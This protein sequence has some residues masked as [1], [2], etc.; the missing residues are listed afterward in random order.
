MTRIIKALTLAPFAA[1]LFAASTA[2]SAPSTTAHETRVQQSLASEAQAKAFVEY[3]GCRPG[4]EPCARR[5]CC[6]VQ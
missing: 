3:G 4:F 2:S 5:G 1:M 6:V